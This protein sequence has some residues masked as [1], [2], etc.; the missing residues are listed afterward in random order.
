MALKP[1][2][3]SEMKTQILK[4]VSIAV[5]LAVATPVVTGPTGANAAMGLNQ[6][7][8]AA[9][10]NRGNVQDIAR[11]LDNQTRS[12]GANRDHGFNGKS[13][14]NSRDVARV[15]RDLNRAIG[16]LRRQFRR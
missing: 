2:K 10:N 8:N 1:R 9:A 7:A 5:A 3:V 12:G 11:A 4:Y 15:A 14:R 6:L 16:N 13:N